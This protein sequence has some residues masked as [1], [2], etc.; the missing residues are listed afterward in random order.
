MYTKLNI[1]NSWIKTEEIEF[2]DNKIIK[3]YWL[4]ETGMKI[5]QTIYE[6][7]LSRELDYFNVIDKFK[8]KTQEEIVKYSYFWYPKTAIKSKIKDD[9]FKKYRLLEIFAGEL[10]E[11]YNNLKAS[12]KTIKEVIRE[13]W[14]C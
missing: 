14:R 11:E 8:D 9:L 3:N 12:G 1:E 4:T 6:N 13:T 10:E 5:A 2:Q 7:L